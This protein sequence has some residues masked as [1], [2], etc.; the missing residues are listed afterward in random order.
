[1]G[2]Y[3]PPG[4]V[5]PPL[6]SLCLLS[7]AVR[8]DFRKQL[9]QTHILNSFGAIFHHLLS[10]TETNSNVFEHHFIFLLAPSQN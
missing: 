2:L 3:D 6:A 7:A 1:M 10:S 9:D 5:Q 8:W 4:V